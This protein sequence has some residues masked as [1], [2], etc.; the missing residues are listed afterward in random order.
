MHVDGQEGEYELEV[1]EERAKGMGGFWAVSDM[2]TLSTWNEDV[3]RPLSRSRS[4]EDADAR[5]C[6]KF[7][8]VLPSTDARDVRCFEWQT[9]YVIEAFDAPT[10]A[11]GDDLQQQGLSMFVGTQ[12]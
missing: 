1:K 9:D 6:D 2:Q 10:L 11:F 5:A 7:D 3:S 4:R 8:A 12:K